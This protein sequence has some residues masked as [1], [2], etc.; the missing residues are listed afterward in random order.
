MPGPGNACEQ[1]PVDSAPSA[2]T[3]APTVVDL[4]DL[5]HY[6]WGKK[7]ACVHVY[8]LIIREAGASVTSLLITFCDIIYFYCRRTFCIRTRDCLKT[9]SIFPVLTFVFQL[10]GR[11]FLWSRRSEHAGLLPWLEFRVTLKPLC[12][13]GYQNIFSCFIRVP[14]LPLRFQSWIHLDFIVLRNEVDIQLYTGSGKSDTG[15]SVVRRVMIWV[16]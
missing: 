10:G 2:L 14:F 6:K 1:L 7:Q 15:L 9:A 8:V 5:C 16:Q 12:G 4:V 3:A 11:R 13:H